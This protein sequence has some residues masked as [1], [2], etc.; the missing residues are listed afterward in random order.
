MITQK[1]FVRLEDRLPTTDLPFDRSRL[2]HEL[3][4]NLSE[5]QY[6]VK[7]MGMVRDYM[8]F[9]RSSPVDDTTF[10]SLQED[11]E[12]FVK[13]INSDIAWPLAR[14]VVPEFRDQK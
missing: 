4:A 11:V 12:C 1:P 2:N 7:F 13:C 10:Y 3:Y 14:T 6:S 5:P 9:L 8:Q